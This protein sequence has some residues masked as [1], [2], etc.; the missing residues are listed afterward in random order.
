MACGFASGLVIVYAL[1]GLFAAL[2]GKPFGALTQN[3]WIYFVMAALFVI[4]GALTIRGA[5]FELPAAI[6]GRLDALRGQAV[7]SHQGRAAW[8]GVLAAVV[9]GAVSG[10]IVSPCTGPVLA[11]AL[12]HV[13]QTKSAVYGFSLFFAI[14]SGMALP[15]VFL[16]LF[17]AQLTRLPRSGEWMEVVKRA[18][19]AVIFFAAIY[20]L[21]Q[22][23]RRSPRRS[24]A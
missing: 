9:I 13:A 21:N 5:G 11:A 12:V 10:L 16:G 6:S 19:G 3:P 7:A 14:G 2:A 15:F 4:F 18:I 1:L 24:R 23:R 8:V 20:F 17:S 22:G